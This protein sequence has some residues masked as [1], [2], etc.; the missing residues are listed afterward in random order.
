[1][2]RSHPPALATWLFERLASGPHREALA[3]DLVEQYAM[4]R[5]RAWYW[6]QTLSAI[7][8]SSITDV[9]DHKLLAARGLAVGWTVLLAL[10]FLVVPTVFSVFTR[11]N[12][13]LGVWLFEGGWDRAY[14]VWTLTYF[15]EFA[16]FLPLWTMAA[17][18]GW[19][20]GRS[21]RGQPN[22][23]V[24]CFALSV[25]LVLMPV[26]L[27]G[28]WRPFAQSHIPLHHSSG[29]PILRMYVPALVVRDI[30]G[31]LCLV[32]AGLSGS[33]VRRMSTAS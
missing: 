10:R 18:V 4:G 24:L 30:I 22:A 19:C 27:I 3:G 32:S 5:S 25:L 11:A 16:T 12:W 7:I 9:R 33:T 21:H 2:R 23:V 17:L 31:L 1:M 8:V 29:L 26:W 20:V 28:F 15:F 6:R 14:R 13:S